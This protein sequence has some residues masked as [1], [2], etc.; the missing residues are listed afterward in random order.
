MLVECRITV[1]MKFDPTVQE[2]SAMATA[3]AAVIDSISKF[4]YAGDSHIAAMHVHV[5]PSSVN[6][7]TSKTQQA[8]AT[9]DN[10]PEPVQSEIPPLELLNS[11][12]GF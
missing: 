4:R 5:L 9:Y 11:N 10:Y 3:A 7:V 8:P 1:V 2:S 12:D 6:T